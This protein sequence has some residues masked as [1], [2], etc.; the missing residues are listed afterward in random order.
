M[1]NKNKEMIQIKNNNLKQLK[2]IN[3]NN[4]KNRKYLIKD[5]SL[6]F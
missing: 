5:K 1:Y 3:N 6:N 2:K 4:K